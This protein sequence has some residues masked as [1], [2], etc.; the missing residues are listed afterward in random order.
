MASGDIVV[1]ELGRGRNDPSVVRIN[2]RG[3]RLCV[4]GVVASARNEPVTYADCNA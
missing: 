2:A 1:D 4:G 3:A